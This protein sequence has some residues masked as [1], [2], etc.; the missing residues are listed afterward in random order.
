MSD[1]LTQIMETQREQLPK[2]KRRT[3]EADFRSFPGYEKVRIPFSTSLKLESTVSVI[4]EF[5]RASPSKGDIRVHANVQE[6]TNQYIQNG[7]SAL[8]VL[9][10]EPYF[11]GKR[12]DIEQIFS[13]CPI[14]ILRKEF[15]FDP[16]QITE[17]RA[18][19]SDAVL[20]IMAALEF[21]QIEELLYAASEEG[22][23]VLLECDHVSHIEKLTDLRDRVRVVGVNNRDLKSFTMDQ[24]AGLA[25]LEK[26][27]E[28]Y[29]RVSESGHKSTE[30]LKK[31]HDAGIEAVLIGTSLMHA[32][33]PGEELSNLLKYNT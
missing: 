18:I 7:A 20:L 9:T 24:D 29:V 21:S 8:S 6:I 33:N 30:D 28:S 11:K 2:A 15:I 27:P 13:A 3:A 26:I 23:E 25:L 16:W 19:G 32:E 22:L 5:K 10:N 14:P 4:A 17:S 1:I 31:V 12:E